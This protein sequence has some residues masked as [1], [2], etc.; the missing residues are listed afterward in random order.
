M[1]SGEYVKMLVDLQSTGNQGFQMNR[2]GKTSRKSYYFFLKDKSG[3]PRNRI[4]YERKN[5]VVEPVFAAVK[6]DASYKPRFKFYEIVK[7]SW[8][9]KIKEAWAKAWA[10]HTA[11]VIPAGM[12]G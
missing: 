3:R 8:D 10:K 7:E 1:S 9:K 12:K 4:I 5:G 11:A 2:N 6:G